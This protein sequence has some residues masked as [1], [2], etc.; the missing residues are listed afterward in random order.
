MSS[1]KGGAPQAGAST[2]RHSSS[3]QTDSIGRGIRFLFGYDR[4][5]LRR[6]PVLLTSDGR[7]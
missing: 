7:S 4:S 2:A 6:A 3:G 5:G 1:T